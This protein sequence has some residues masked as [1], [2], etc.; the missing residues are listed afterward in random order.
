MSEIT[1]ATFI[2]DTN[3]S[4]QERDCRAAFQWATDFKREKEKNFI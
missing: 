3:S 1:P 2:T 4:V